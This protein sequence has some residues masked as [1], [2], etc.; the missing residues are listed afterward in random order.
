MA[1]VG[2]AFPLRGGIA[3]FNE[4]LARNLIQ[5]GVEVELFSFSYQ[6]PEFLF[7]GK[8][9]FR[10]NEAPPSDLKI[11]SCLNSINP[12]SWFKTAKAIRESEADLVLVRYWMPFMAP[13]LG[14]LI[15][16]LKSKG[17]PVIVLA[18]NVIPHES[19]P[20]QDQLNA[21]ILK[22]ADAFLVMSRSVEKDL[23][24][25]LPNPKLLR[26]PH[27]IY[28]VFGEKIEKEKA[29]SSLKIPE[30]E[31]WILF[32]GFIRKYKGLHLLLDAMA[33]P[34]L[35]SRGVKLL[36]AGEFYDESD[37][38]FDKVEKLGLKDRVRF[39]DDFIPTEEVKAYFSATDLVVQPYITATQS[40]ISQIAYQ[41]D[42][43]M[44]VTNV[45]GLGEWI[46]DTVGYV[47]EPNPFEVATAI[48]DFFEN[49]RENEMSS[50]AAEEKKRFDWKHFTKG[51]MHLAQDLIQ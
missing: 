3:D 8:S 17:V 42:K 7:P 28:N 47:V 10:E 6:Y 30:G 13:A 25:Y 50:A 4:S 40:G 19:M 26:I 15:R 35:K 1:I 38:Y 24:K 12:F 39:D 20:L 27:P 34:K 33:E 51:V 44:V 29:R 5:E 11:H 41:F 18:D 46:P 22:K 9:Q 43:P 37:S 2:P 49:Q 16:L 31:P 14:T 32:F 23:K 36:V 45:G 48:D 21:Y